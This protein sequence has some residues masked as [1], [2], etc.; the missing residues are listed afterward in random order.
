[1]LSGRSCESWS[2][3]RLAPV[4]LPGE[5]FAEAVENTQET[6]IA[7]LP[8]GFSGL[9]LPGLVLYSGDP[10]VSLW[11][12]EMTHQAQMRREGVLRYGFNYAR[13]WIV[14]RYQGCG[15]L[16]SYH[17]IRYE[18][19]AH[20]VARVRSASVVDAYGAGDRTALVAEIR[21]LDDVG[22]GGRRFYQYL[23]DLL[24]QY[25]FGMSFPRGTAPSDS[26]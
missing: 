20:G 6:D 8:A 26:K 14:G 16:D 15:P 24:G 5:V 22:S 7:W 11:L 18:R 4:A 13:D 25:R 17:A 21:S 1:M 10:D 19:E 23:T 3:R 9:S 2:S 12:H